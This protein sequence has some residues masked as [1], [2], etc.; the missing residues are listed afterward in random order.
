MIDKPLYQNPLG[1]GL[2]NMIDKPGGGNV[3]RGGDVRG[4][5]GAGNVPRGGIGQT[6]AD[7]FM[8]NGIYDMNTSGMLLPGA[9][10]TSTLNVTPPSVPVSEQTPLPGIIDPN[11]G[12]QKKADQEFLK[13]ADEYQRGFRESEFYKPGGAMTTDMA[14]FTYSS[15]TRGDITMKGSS[16]GIGQFGSYLDSIGKGDLLQRAGG[17]FSQDL[18]KVNPND[19][20]DLGSA[21]VGVNP[22]VSGPE[23]IASTATA[24]GV[25]QDIFGNNPAEIA[26][27]SNPFNRVGQQL[28]GPD[29]NN[30]VLETLKNIEQG[31]ASLGQGGMNQSSFGGFDN[32]FGIGSFFPPY[33]GM[34]GQ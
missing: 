18:A 24:P 6:S 5:P 25:G 33:G 32:N 26:V 2:G 15:P 21:K 13:T 8:G 27:P 3:P 10:G 23:G 11:A 19:P 16:S 17:S 20:Y 30:N 4:N 31:I 34:Y 14:E 1:G 7:M 22:I 9:P 29:Q 12:A 28:T